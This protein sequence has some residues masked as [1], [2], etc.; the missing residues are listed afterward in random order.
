MSHAPAIP[1][2]RAWLAAGLAQ[3]DRLPLRVVAG[4]ALLAGGFA[5]GLALTAEYWGGLLPCSLCLLGNL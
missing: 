3:I 4:L 2:A 5:L 1:T